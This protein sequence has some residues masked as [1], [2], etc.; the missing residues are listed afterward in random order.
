MFAL[1]TSV[2]GITHKLGN[3][4]HAILALAE[5]MRDDISGNKGGHEVAENIGRLETIIEQADR[6]S[7]MINELRE[8]ASRECSEV[9]PT[10]V[11][12]VLESAIKLLRFDRRF[13]AIEITTDLC[14]EVPMVHAVTEHLIQV[15]VNLLVNAAEAMGGGEGRIMVSSGHND[16]SAFITVADDGC[17]WSTEASEEA[18]DAPSRTE[19]KGAGGMWRL[20]VCKTI[21]DQHRGSLEVKSELDR[22]NRVFIRIPT[23]L[24]AGV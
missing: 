2:A 20:A 10:S 9:E 12:L 3:S 6:M 7:Q 22:G 5:R 11:N 1:G 16:D 13:Q 14:R 18:L 21:I 24:E 15:V 8:L 4:V 19:A 17:T 23:P